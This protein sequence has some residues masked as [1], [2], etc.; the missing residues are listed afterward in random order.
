MPIVKD[1]AWKELKALSYERVSGTEGEKRAAEELKSVCEE[2]GVQVQ[3]EP[4]E[5]DQAEIHTATL[6]VLGENGR[7]YT[8]YGINHS[9]CTPEEGI[10]AP[11]QYIGAGDLDA[12]LLNVQG[13]IVLCTGLMLPKLIRKLKEKG[14]IGFINTHGGFCDDEVITNGPRVRNMLPRE[15]NVEFPGV[16]IHLRDAEDL[17]KNHAGAKVC[18]K[19]DQISGA[20]S[21]QNVVATI[22]GT[23]YPEETIVISAHYDTVIHS[24]G[25]WDNGSGCVVLLE[26]MRHFAENPPERT[27]RFLWCGCEEI[28]LVGS[29]KYC[30][31]HKDDLEKVIYN[32]NID[33]VGVTL[34]RVLFCCSGDE[35]VLHGLENF[36]KMKGFPIKSELG[37]YSSDSTSFA[38]AGVPASS[39]GQESVRGGA[40]IHNYRDTMEHMD[41]E[42]LI[43]AI[44]FI[45]DYVSQIVNAAVNL[46]PRTFALKVQ[47]A[48]EEGKK[49]RAEMSGKGPEENE[50]KSGKED[51]EKK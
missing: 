13:K 14:A 8:A 2:L 7:E 30:E 33:M 39:F 31:Q 24:K 44:E 43:Q 6:T 10:T 20:G 16:S 47:E 4:F 37:T 42:S 9:G 18:L 22:P 29:R 28:G 21:S 35:C 41:P 34:G 46:I 40:E 15:A 49:R 50:D 36:A 25:S 12:D 5:I 51:K 19:L 1:R 17:I 27:L 11:V 45:L 32:I 38:A 26:L 48:L 3:T 23:K